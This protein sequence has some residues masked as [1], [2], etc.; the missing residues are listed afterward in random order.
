MSN[1]KPKGMNLDQLRTE[2]DTEAQKRCRAQEKTIKEMEVQLIQRKD[3]TTFLANRCFVHTH[4][5]LCSLCR[6]R[7]RCSCYKN[8]VAEEGIANE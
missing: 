4:G 7:D 1:N 5:L 2:L 3:D 8:A 6:M